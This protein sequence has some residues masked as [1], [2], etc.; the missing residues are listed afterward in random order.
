M[1]HM[2]W[3][4][5]FGSAAATLVLRQIRRRKAFLFNG[6]FDVDEVPVLTDEMLSFYR[7]WT[8]DE[9]VDTAFIVSNWRA[10]KR[11]YHTFR[12]VQGMMYLTPRASRLTGYA[13]ILDSIASKKPIKVAD[14]GTCF[15]QDVRKLILDGVPAT[16]IS[17]FD[18]HDGYW[19]ASVE[20]FK[21]GGKN[22]KLH[23]VKTFFFDLTLPRGNP[24]AIESTHPAEVGTYDFIILQAV[25]HTISLEQQKTAIARLFLLLKKG[26]CLLGATGG[27]ET[28]Q[29]WILTP[30]GNAARYLQS[31]SSLAALLL[32]T[33]FANADAV[34][35]N[36]WGAV[37]SG[38]QGQRLSLPVDEVL[39][40]RILVEFTAV[41]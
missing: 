9:N 1:S 40:G 32:D 18:L 17:A 39:K 36:A 13:R 25:L 27:S 16:S 34:S 19:R 20:L 24:D 10:L 29:N 11:Q 28:A 14:A 37:L 30:D 41:K 35:R 12:C 26:G 2:G 33:G 6:N 8:G 4:L 31:P 38:E 23:G 15:G 22:S 21:D 7:R 5:F 3:A